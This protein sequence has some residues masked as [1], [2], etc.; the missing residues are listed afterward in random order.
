MTFTIRNK[1][2]IDKNTY[3]WVK[4]SKNNKYLLKGFQRHEL[5]AIVNNFVM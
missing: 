4:D 5:F 2:K 3:Y 1:Q